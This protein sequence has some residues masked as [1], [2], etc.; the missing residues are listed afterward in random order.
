MC[1]C[2]RTFRD[3]FG[4]RTHREVLIEITFELMR[5]GWWSDLSRLLNWIVPTPDT[6]TRGNVCG[7]CIRSAGTPE[8]HFKKTRGVQSR[9][10]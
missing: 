7:I 6:W 2:V 3:R 10:L 5:S 1:T 8:S 4:T 9:S